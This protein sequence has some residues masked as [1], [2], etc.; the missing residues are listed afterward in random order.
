ML[1]LN[2]QECK[3]KS[4]FYNILGGKLINIYFNHYSYRSIGS[5]IFIT[6]I[7][8]NFLY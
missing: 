2:F 6:Y 4:N 1:K 5:I 8:P 3:N 7:N